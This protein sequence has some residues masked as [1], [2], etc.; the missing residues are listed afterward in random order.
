MANLNWYQYPSIIDCFKDAW[1]YRFSSND[2]IRVESKLDDEH[3]PTLLAWMREGDTYTLWLSSNGDVER[4]KELAE[5]GLQIWRQ[6][7]EGRNSD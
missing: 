7:P 3:M 5:D 4:A 2:W 1:V 6:V